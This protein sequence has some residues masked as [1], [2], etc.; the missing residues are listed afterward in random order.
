LSSVLASMDGKEYFF[1]LLKMSFWVLKKGQL[2]FSK[3]NKTG[4][5]DNKALINLRMLKFP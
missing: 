4:K 2:S 5:K 1:G 3:G